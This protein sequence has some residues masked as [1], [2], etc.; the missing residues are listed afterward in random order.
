MSDDKGKLNQLVGRLFC[1]QGLTMA[2]AESCTGGLLSAAITDIAGAS[3]YFERGFITYSNQA[4]HEL[5]GVPLHTLD[6]YGAV[7]AQAAAAMVQGVLAHSHADI[8]LSI[9]GIAGP[10]GGSADKPVG[11]V[12]FG[13][14]SKDGFCDTKQQ[15]F[16]GDRGA[17]RQQAVE[18]TLRLAIDYLIRRE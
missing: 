7:S 14:A 11:L 6:T 10:H 16:S 15:I 5:L 2:V 18:F 4:K 9:T 3:A 12:F 17:I 1:A 8:A 13:L